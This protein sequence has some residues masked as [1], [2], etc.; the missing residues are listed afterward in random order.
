MRYVRY[1][2]TQATENV[3]KETEGPLSRVTECADS[4]EAQSRR[5]GDLRAELAESAAA[6]RVLRLRVFSEDV[7]EPLRSAASLASRAASDLEIRVPPVLQKVSETAT[8]LRA[9]LEDLKGALE[10][11]TT[12]AA[13]N[14]AYYVALSEEDDF[15]KR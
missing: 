2:H 9:A 7:Y 11:T 8:G 10:N 15:W 12:S 14:D 1:H 4:L 6:A 13:P 3:R 5:M